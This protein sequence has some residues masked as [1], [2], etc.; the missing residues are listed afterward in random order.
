MPSHPLRR[1]LAVSLLAAAALAV[2]ATDAFA[3]HFRYG[4]ITWTVVNPARPNVVTIRFESAWRLSYE[5]WIPASPTAVGQVVTT[6]LANLG[7]IIVRNS[8]G[9][10][11]AAF[12][13]T[14]KVTSLNSAEDWF[15]AS[16]EA[17][18]TFPQ[19]TANYTAI[20]TACCRISTLRDD[21][22]DRDYMVQAGITIKAPP[23]PVNQPP[24]SATVP[25]ITLAK[26]RPAVLQLPASDPNGDVVTFRSA[27]F[28]ES[29]LSQPAPMSP[30]PGALGAFHLSP[31][32]LVRWT[33]DTNGLYAAQVRLTDA[34]GA[35]TVIDV[36]FNVVTANGEAPAVQINNQMGAKAFTTVHGTPVSFKVTGTDPENTPVVLSSSGLPVGSTMTPSLPMTAVNASSTFYWT[37]APSAI[38]TYVMSFAALDGAGLQSTNFV[39]LIVTNNPATIN[40][41]TN[42]PFLE[43]TDAAGAP[44]AITAD[45]DDADRDKLTIRFFV[46]GAEHQV[47]AL[48][49]PP[50][51]QSF[52]TVFGLGSHTY[53]ARVDDGLGIRSCI[54]TF[55][56]R[57][58]TAPSIVVAP[59]DQTLAAAASA[60]AVATFSVTAHD[61]VDPAPKV[62]C[63]HASG[64]TFPIAITT[65]TCSA[66]DASGNRNSASFLI[67][68][69]DPDPPVIDPHA[70]VTAE[71]TSAAGA[72]VNYMPPPTHD[73]I[74]GMGVAT[75]RP[76]SG[77]TF[78]IG[79]TIVTCSAA[80]AFGN[81]A[82]DTTFKVT[83]ADTTPPT[84]DPHGNERVNATSPA[85]AVVTYTSP[86]THDAVSGDGVATC[87]PASGSTFAIATTTVHCS[88]TDA[89]GNHA[90]EVTFTVTVV[91]TAPVFIPPADVTVEAT[92]AAG[93]IVAF[94]ANADDAEQGVIP[95][96]CSQL[97]G[98]T[99]VIGTTIVRCNV[100]DVAGASASGSF[101]VTVRDTTAP[102]IATVTPSAVTLPLPS[103]K[104]EPVTIAV[105]AA[106]VVTLAPMCRITDVNSNE[107]QN[108]VGDGNTRDDW[109]VTGALTLLLRAERAG[110]G[111]GRIYTITIECADDAGNASS[112]ATTVSVAKSAGN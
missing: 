98:S 89:H 92:S 77:S 18:V 102:S 17:T 76:P 7:Q 71:A 50:A 103:H 73:A 80:D 74:D 69:I 35:F 65:V 20:F 110:T 84:I 90:V 60:G 47:A 43:A 79:V 109:Q 29:G 42:G 78:A 68:V 37:P 54:G 85:G 13:P 45:V 83:V 8:A 34:R 96:V 75:C 64:A 15:A 12:T 24:T 107:A 9:V 99:F 25:I 111:T 32:G 33:P 2:S 91:N 30:A 87:S 62:E 53:E 28:A 52:S 40:C 44:F 56:V 105:S 3:S 112:A 106:D 66:T 88:A 108:G 23:N 86:A 31:S 101:S 16:Y 59:G 41:T 6:G 21:N 46:D 19:T 95:A 63:S 100:T 57:D 38:G 48:L 93:A 5:Q 51:S 39:T 70:D 22:A 61:D 104:M 1:I 97:A 58:T 67:N 10:A 82:T 26:D 72:I 4:T 36:I 94:A 11:I 49:T 55:T 27:T 14:L 81:H